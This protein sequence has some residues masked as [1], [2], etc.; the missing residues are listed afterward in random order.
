MSDKYLF[1]S[2]L[3]DIQGISINPNISAKVQALCFY[4][5]GVVQMN[6]V[7]IAGL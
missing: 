3:I 7:E 5:V 6:F 4:N 2:G 1:S